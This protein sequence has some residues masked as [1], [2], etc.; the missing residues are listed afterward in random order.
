MALH[1]SAGQLAR[2]MIQ[3]QDKIRR[4]S[5]ELVRLDQI[6]SG[7][8]SLTRS[9]RRTMAD[10]K[11]DLFEMREELIQLADRMARHANLAEI[12][13]GGHAAGPSLENG[14]GADQRGLNR[15]FQVGGARADMRAVHDVAT[16]GGPPDSPRRGAE[17]RD[18]VKRAVD[19][20]PSYVTDDQRE[21]AVRLVERAGDPGVSGPGKIS[22]AARIA[23]HILRT[24]HPDYVDAFYGY[25]SNP[26][27][28]GAL[29]PRQAQAVRAALNEGTTTQ[30]GFLVPPFLDPTIILTNNSATNPFREIATIKTITTQTWKGVTSAGVTAE[31]TAEAAQAADA[32]PTVSQPSIT[33]VRADAWVQAS[34]EV[35]EDTDIGQ[36]IAMLMQ[37]ARDRLEATAFAVGT[38]ST[39]PKGVITAVSAVTASRVAGSSGAAGSADFVVADVFNLKNALPPRYRPNSSWVAEQT[40]Y[41]KVRQFASGTGQQS[42][43]FWADLGAAIP[44]LLLGRPTYETSEMRNVIVSGSN[45]DVLL[46]GD[47]KKLYIVDRIGMSIAYEPLVKGA[48]Q[49]PT[50]EVGWFAFWRVG[51]DVVDANA[52]RLLRL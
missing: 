1:D 37:D 49:R 26:N 19:S 12:V 8:G 41:G 35:I 25:L 16:V 6:E 27:S 21:S 46:I 2:Q 29:E 38:G 17:L 15:S 7:G 30:G 22:Q 32:T 51:S 18:R 10:H 3:L 40:I 45:D 48:N 50:G 28:I 4:T 9:D 39:Q 43:A 34:F 33:P 5:D 31:W 36:E 42:G 14:D 24:G 11:E 47:F 13:G 52:F 20:W 44:P 23:E